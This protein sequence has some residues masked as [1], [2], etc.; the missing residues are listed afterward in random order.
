MARAVTRVR[1]LTDVACGNG[2]KDLLIPWCL[3]VCIAHGLIEIPGE[4]G[5]IPVVVAVTRL[6]VHSVVLVV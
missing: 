2:Q 3:V 1:L 4:R 5:V 6:E